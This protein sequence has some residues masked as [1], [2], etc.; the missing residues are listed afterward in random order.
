VV[1][2]VWLGIF[3]CA[4]A[5]SLSWACSSSI[6]HGRPQPSS[7]FHGNNARHVLDDRHVA[8]DSNRGARA[9]E[10]RAPAQYCVE[11]IVYPLV[12]ESIIGE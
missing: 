12:D 8:L 11:P 3:R 2:G 9:G 5:P 10:I 6:L 7:Y 1:L 4:R